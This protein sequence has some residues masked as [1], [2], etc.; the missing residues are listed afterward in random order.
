LF[1]IQ[2]QRTFTASSD[3]AAC[4]TA[5][6]LFCARESVYQGFVE[7]KNGMH[8]Y[9]DKPLFYSLSKYKDSVFE[10]GHT[11]AVRVECQCALDKMESSMGKLSREIKTEIDAL[12]NSY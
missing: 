12:F 7:E 6:A 5:E 1:L 2:N 9:L 4:K 8:E 10:D 11:E 3:E